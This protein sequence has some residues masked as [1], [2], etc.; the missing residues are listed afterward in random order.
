[1]SELKLGHDIKN[2]LDDWRHE[3]D[4]PIKVSDL[5]Y[6]PY[7]ITSSNHVENPIPYLDSSQDHSLKKG[8]LI[9]GIDGSPIHSSPELLSSLQEKKALVIVQRKAGSQ[10]LLWTEADAAFINSFN[11]QNL[12]ALSNKTMN[13]PAE[14]GD[15]VLLPPLTLLS[16]SDLPMT[17]KERASYEKDIQKAKDAIEKNLSGEKRDLLLKDLE[18]GRHRLILGIKPTDEQVNYNPSPLILFKNGFDQTW[19][20][21]ANLFQGSA[22][23]KDLAGPVGIV[24]AL[25][26]S[27][28]KSVKDALFW[29][30]FI[31]LNLAFLNLLPI[32]VLD[33]GHIVFS[34][35][36]AITGKRI[37]SKTMEKLII[38]FIVLLILLFIFTT[39]QDI[40]R[41][42]QKPF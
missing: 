27:W 6:I 11:P 8:D 13:G 14:E 26:A 20:V 25:Q 18:A 23:P 10:P 42:F 38:P 31:S 3:A 37:K 28:A 21:F 5:L 24:T 41:I 40:F 32:P 2:E 22:S 34:L 39:Y 19:K 35:W 15:L 16:Y 30:G 36:E 1:V 17:P 12:E 9:L 33:G 4:L 29:L 7:N